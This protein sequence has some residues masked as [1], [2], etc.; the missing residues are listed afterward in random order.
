MQFITVEE[1]DGTTLATEVI[2]KRSGERGF[3]TAR[4]AKEPEHRVHELR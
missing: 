3:A 4:Q 2:A 1:D